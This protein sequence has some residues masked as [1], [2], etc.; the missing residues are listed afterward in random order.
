MR[1]LVMSGLSIILLMAGCG[2]I[3]TPP[4]QATA[5]I[6]NAR[7]SATAIVREAQITGLISPTPTVTPTHTSTATPN[8]T[9]TL[10]PSNTPSPA[11]TPTLILTNTLVAPITEEISGDA[12]NGEVLFNTFQ[13]AA[14]FACATCHRTDSEERLIGPGLFNVSIRAE[15]RVAG[16][17]ATEYIY[18]SITNP[19]TYVVEGFPDRLMP[20]SWADIYSEEEIYD[21]I[22]YLFTLHD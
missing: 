1:W 11:H 6:R 9:D 15:S 16:L 13:P 5:L 4:Y 18:Q 17:D 12:A 20:Q 8:P 3:A 10:L 2:T 14:S 22:A 19:S 7:G 21:I